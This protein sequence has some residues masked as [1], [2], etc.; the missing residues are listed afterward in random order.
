[1]ENRLGAQRFSAATR[2]VTVGYR[3]PTARDAAQLADTIDKDRENCCHE[4][5]KES[6]TRK[7][8]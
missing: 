5:E 2:C 1:V 6:P 3:L 8:A 4:D 7:T